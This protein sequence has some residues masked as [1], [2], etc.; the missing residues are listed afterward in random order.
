MRTVLLGGAGYIGSVVAR[1]LLHDGHEVVVVDNMVYAH[2]GRVDRAPDGADF[3]KADFRDPDVLRA[4]LEGADAV[5]HLGGLVGEP[6]CAVDEELAVQLNYA[7][8][9]LAAEIA[10]EAG[11]GKYVF[12][13]TCSVY[14]RQKDVLVTEDV[15][16]A[17]LSVYARTKLLAEEHLAEV[18]RGEIE[19]T[20]LRLSTV[21]GLSPRMR[22]DS[23]VNSMTSRAVVKAVVPLRGGGQWRPLV[24]VADVADVVRR[25]LTAE[26]AG[27]ATVLNVGSDG[28]NHS[29]KQIAEAVVSSVPGARIDEQEDAEDR[30]DYRVSFELVARRFPGSCTTTLEAGIREIAGAIERG[31]L[32]DPDRVEYDNLRGLRLALEERR[33]AV[34]ASEPMKRLAGDY[35]TAWGQR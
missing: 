7:A 17:P 32:G 23:V 11:V 27:E 1:E 4:A 6:A 35:A 21:F 5:V 13:S 3:R 29:I 12:L 25:A 24:H 16:P 30:R 20:T 10:V 15:E 34:V 31:E 28:Q 9:V 26:P 18:C 8:P 33:I 2:A 14:G 19:L 22:L